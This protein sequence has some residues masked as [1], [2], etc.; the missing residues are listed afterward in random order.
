M[1][2]IY[3][4]KSLDSG[5]FNTVTIRELTKTIDCLI[6][7]HAVKLTLHWIPVHVNIQ[8]NEIADTLGLNG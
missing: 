6:T 2:T 4:L 5:I 8:D 7:E 1:G 3:V